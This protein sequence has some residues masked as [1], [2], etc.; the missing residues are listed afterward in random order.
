VP[1]A[2]R[3]LIAALGALVACGGPLDGK[4]VAAEVDACRSALSE[5]LLLADEA[6][7]HHL[8]AS[9]LV[10]QRE[11]LSGRL[12]DALDE[13]DRGASPPNAEVAAAAG[14]IGHALAPALKTLDPGDA[15]ARERIRAGLAQH[16]AL[17]GRVEGAR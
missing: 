12:A 5:S 8:V 14:R 1:R 10:T 6:A 16:E 13:L 9:T 11:A 3:A 15:A 7:A 2:R 17:R 4:R